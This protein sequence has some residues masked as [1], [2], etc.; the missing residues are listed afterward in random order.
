MINSKYSLTTISNRYYQT[1]NISGNTY[2][3]NLPQATLKEDGTYTEGYIFVHYI[4]INEPYIEYKRKMIRKER[5]EKLKKL[6]W[7]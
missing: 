4:I 6:G 5:K 3:T 2:V 7:I 1:T